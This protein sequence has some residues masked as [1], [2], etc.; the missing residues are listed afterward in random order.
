VLQAIN[1]LLRASKQRGFL[2][3]DAGTARDATAYESPLVLN[4][5]VGV[6]DS[7]VCVLDFASLYPSLIIGF[8]SGSTDPPID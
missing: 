6:Q 4:P 5:V 1:L 2:V 7:P 8:N 3:P